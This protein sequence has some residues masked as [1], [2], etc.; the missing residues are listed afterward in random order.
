VEI[1]YTG[2]FTKLEKKIMDGWVLLTGSK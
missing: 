2:T 1:A